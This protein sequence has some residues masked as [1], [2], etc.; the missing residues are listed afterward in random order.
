MH[1]Y[2]LLTLITTLYMQLNP[3]DEA[4]IHVQAQIYKKG[5]LST[6]QHKINDVAG[7]LCI[8][9]PALLTQRGLLL[10]EV[11]KCL[12][13]SGY[14]YKKGK[15]RSKHFGSGSSTDELSPPTRPK[16]DKELRDMS[17]SKK[18]QVL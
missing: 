14:Q 4:E 16:I 2:Y 17:K 15:C 10:E 7:E 6:Y 12:D 3:T 1:N 8:Q 9:N 13:K 11:R 5:S 18:K